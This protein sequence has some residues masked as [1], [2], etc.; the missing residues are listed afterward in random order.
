[1]HKAGW[2]TA[3]VIALALVFMLALEATSARLKSPTY[4]EQGYIARGYAYVKLGDRHI[5][6]GT[7]MMLNAWNALPLLL[8][9]DVRLETEYPTWEGTD[10]HDVGSHFVWESGN[11]VDKIMFWARVPTMILSLL[12]AVTAYRWARELYGPRAG[13]LALLL[14]ILSPNVLAH[15]R[16]A[17]TDLGLAFF[18]FLATYRFW[19][20]L[21][22]PTWPNLLWAGVALGLS[23]GTKFSALLIAP[24]WVAVGT[25]WA[26]FGE[27]AESRAW[28]RRMLSLALAGAAMAVIGFGVLWATY[29]F[30]IAPLTEGG[31]PV[32]AATHFRQWSDVS[33]R[34][35][36]AAT[37][38][39]PAFLTGRYSDTGWWY[40]FPVAFLLKTP[41]PTLILLLWAVVL[42]L[43]RPPEAAP[44]PWRRELAVI[45]PPAIY[46]TLSLTSKLNL[47]YRYLLPVLPFLFVY[48]SKIAAHLPPHIS[49]LTFHVSRP[50]P[51]TLRHA[52]LALLIGWY[53]LGSTLI[54]PHYL[55]YFNEL[56]GGPEG[57]WRYLVDSNIDWGQDAI[58]LQRY[59]DQHGIDK[60]KL[61]WFGESRP[62]YYGLRYEPLP[63]WPPN[64][65]NIATRTF[66]PVAPSPGVYAISVTN[67]QGVLLDDPDTY[68]WFREREPIDKIGYSVFIY[69][70]SRQGKGPVNL[71]LSGLGVDQ[72]GQDAF[73]TLGTN[74]LAPR[75]F[76]ARSSLV[77][78]AGGGWYAVA[79]GTL[80][81]PA[82]ESRFWNQ[83]QDSGIY[84]TRDGAIDYY[85]YRLGKLSELAA[86]TA[87]S[88]VWWSPAT[89]FPLDGFERYRLPWPVN[90]GDT[91]ELLGYETNPQA[92]QTGDVVTLLTYWRVRQGN[93]RPLQIFAHLLDEMGQV[94]GG[95]DRLDVAPAGWREGDVL[96]QAHDLALPNDAASATYQLEMGWYDRE[97]MLR[98]PVLDDQG[99]AVADR[100]LLTSVEVSK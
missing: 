42:S 18:F 1:M 96:V 31:P 41:L 84:R 66:S 6:I 59:L 97:T 80:P 70:V 87:N 68:A 74:D 57:G 22:A 62:E 88:P 29:G 51:H 64:R 17:T 73:E 54:Y 23:Q 40:Y 82:L 15:A 10:F 76:D 63:G 44:R 65:E 35:A 94:K 78:P 83:V 14:T 5:L 93:D 13:W 25:A 43:R 75:W 36:G 71:A 38:R 69:E 12:L 3:V 27:R 77:F 9:P 55:A 16:L 79:E 81:D 47:G 8:L 52:L 37:R 4:D 26:F 72:L 33:G 99:A 49:R 11:D 19:R 50:T 60:V 56:A 32:P 7:P 92:L 86:W 53:A 95:Q 39:A 90:F 100:V 91:V 89:T 85:L 34:L 45:L 21:E 67:L 24:V 46:L 58:L 2:R 61:A 48:V 98:L 30:E 28:P 20:Y